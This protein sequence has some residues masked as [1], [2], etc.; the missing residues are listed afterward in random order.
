MSAEMPR[1][2]IFIPTKGRSAWERART[3]RCMVREDIPFKAVVEEQEL[4]AY[5]QLAGEDCFLVL[6]FQDQGLVAARNWIKDQQPEGPGRHWQLDDNIDRAYRLYK[7]ERYPCSTAAALRVCEDLSDRYERV[8]VSGLNYDMFVTRDTNTP[9]R[10][11]VHVYSC[12]LVNNEIPHRWRGSRN[13]DTDLC[14]QVLSDGWFTI[15]VNVFSIKKWR[16]MKIAG[17]NTDDL[18]QG[19][20]RLEMARELERRW[21]GVVTV[22][23]RWSHAQHVVN[24]RKFF[25]PLVRKPDVD[26]AALPETDEYG[27]EPTHH[28]E[29]RFAWSF[30][31]K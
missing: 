6:P 15:L 2:P 3:I 30:N 22:D 17:G 9:F 7:G 27:L 25:R 24:W 4:A 19:D 10:V 21:P 18:Y 12:S 26:L 11:N 29:G 14:L 23:R 20:G 1:Y 5:R 31:A 8:A 28:A 13:D 16:T